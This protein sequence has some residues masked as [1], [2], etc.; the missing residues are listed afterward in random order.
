MGTASRVP[1]SGTTEIDRP[2]EVVT[3][4][5]VEDAVCDLAWKLWGPNTPA[6]IAAELQCSPRAIERYMEGKRKWSGEA[7]ALVVE[8]LLRRHRMRNVKVKAR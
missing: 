3:D 7:V 5:M 2:N 1:K 6:K 4:Q 8:E